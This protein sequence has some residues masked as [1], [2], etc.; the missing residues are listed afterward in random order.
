MWKEWLE[1]VVVVV[2]LSILIVF[3]D[4]IATQLPQ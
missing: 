1:V 2:S 3:I 4:A